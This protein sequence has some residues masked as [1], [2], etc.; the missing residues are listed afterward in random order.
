MSEADPAAEI[1][2]A[3]VDVLMLVGAVSVP[4]FVTQLLVLPLVTS[5]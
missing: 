1:T 2:T 3:F 5:E 4:F